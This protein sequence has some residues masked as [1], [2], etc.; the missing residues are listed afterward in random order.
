MRAEYDVEIAWRAFELHPGI[1]PEGEPIPWPPQRL[2]GAL[3]HVRQM[4]TQVGLPVADRTHWYNSVPA[5]E[6]AEWAHDHASHEVEEAFRR[7]L[8]RAY[9]AE[10]R[11]IGDPD[12]LVELASAEGLDG[13]ALRRSLD[14]HEYLERVHA[15]FQEARE[16]GVT[17]VPTYVAGQYGLVGAQPYE[18]FHELMAAAGASKRHPAEHPPHE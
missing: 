11:N 13:N 17:G 4:A 5:H 18:A 1:P 15:Q 8:F 6:A 12:V 3:E 16:L 7:A 9:F 10:G 14:A 2:A